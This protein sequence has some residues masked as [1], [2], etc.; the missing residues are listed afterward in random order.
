MV[1]FY[2]AFFVGLKLAQQYQEISKA[3]YL[4]QDVDT[5]DTITEWVEPS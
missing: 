5:V 4:T 1:Y 2:T 3:Y